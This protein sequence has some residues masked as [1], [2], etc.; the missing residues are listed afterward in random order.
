MDTP[1]FTDDFNAFLRL[2]DAHAVEYLLV[3]GYA[4]AVH[5]YPRATADLDI[6]VA[7][8]AENATRVVT[9]LSAFGFDTAELSADLF[10]DPDSL[11][12]LGRPPFQI[13]LMT[14]IDGV[15]FDEC[16]RRAL[17]IDIDGVPVPVI[18]LAD[19]RANK[20]AAGRYKDL[21][22]LEQLPDA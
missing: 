13:E 14:S 16:A 11:V 19:L 7:V 22:D 5:G 2:L 21:A 8:S 17:R 9:V 10:L 20:R 1:L 3:G 18:G 4:V 15:E 12:R 6:W